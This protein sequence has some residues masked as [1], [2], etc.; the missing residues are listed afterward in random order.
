MP[1]NFEF[2][3]FWVFYLVPLPLLIIW[4]LP[5]VR[6]R[7]K[8]LKVSFLRHA[9]ELSGQQPTK[10]VRQLKRPWIRQVVLWALWTL[11]LISL[12]RPRLVGEPDLV[13]K[14]SRNFLMVADISFSMAQKDWELGDEKV[15]RWEA[16]KHLMGKFIEEREGDR[17]GILLFGSNAYT[18]APFTSDSHALLQLLDDTDVGMA[19]QQT[20]IGRAIGK[21]I[22][23]FANDTLP[24]KV[25]LLLTDGADSGIGVSPF[26][27]A[28]LANTDSITIHTIGIGDPASLGADLDEE[29]LQHIS[30]LTSGQY[31]LAKDASEMERVFEVLEEIEPVE[32]EDETYVPV[33]ELYFYPLAALFAFSFFTAF[34]I[35]LVKLFKRKEQ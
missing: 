8:S 20:N 11:A 7:K 27:A 15:S 6:I 13:V 1:D 2:A 5:A 25:L 26:D 16:V 19:G 14:T 33:Q 30:K 9:A 21:S 32:Y 34:F 31:F 10:G 18:L 3:Y 35:Y 4:V 29:A 23:L 17:M 22:E 28:E 12:A 24:N